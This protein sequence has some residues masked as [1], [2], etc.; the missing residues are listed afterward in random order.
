MHEGEVILAIDGV[1]EGY[2]VRLLSVTAERVDGA[3]EER[4]PGFNEPPREVWLGLGILKQTAKFDIVVE[5]GTELG[6]V[7]FIPLRTSH[8]E[9]ESVKVDRWRHIA[10]SAAKQCLRCRVPAID[11]PRSSAEAM[12]SRSFDLVVIAHERASRA[13]ALSDST[14]G[15]AQRILALVG[16]EGGFTSEEVVAA[17]R[18]GARIVSLGPRRLRSETA[19]IVMLAALIHD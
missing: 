8:G 18:A 12:A 2:R 19:A 3:I 16:P 9:R 17:E 6:A 11:F 15:K 14:I 5:K 13:S 4:L 1:A 10:G 7:G